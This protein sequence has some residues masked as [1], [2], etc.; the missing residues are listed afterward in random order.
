MGDGGQEVGPKGRGGPGER[1]VRFGVPQ[2]PPSQGLPSRPE[3]KPGIRLVAQPIYFI[4]FLLMF[5]FP[6]VFFDFSFL[7]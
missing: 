4:H 6:I 2:M 5:H 1:E 3:N 7:L